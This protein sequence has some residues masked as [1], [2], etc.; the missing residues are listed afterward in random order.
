MQE[1]YDVRDPG[2]LV[3]PLSL[4]HCPHHY[5]ARQLMATSTLLSAGRGENKMGRGNSTLFVQG[6]NPKITHK[7]SV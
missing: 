5:D 7:L 3:A 4:G 2:S 6:S 1:L